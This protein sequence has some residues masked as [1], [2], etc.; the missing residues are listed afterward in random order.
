ME[1][2]TA[3]LLTLLLLALLYWYGIS[4]F[5]SLE[6]LGI[7]VIKPYPYIGSFLRPWKVLCVADDIRHARTYGRVWG[8]YEGSWP[9]VFIADIEM[10]K[11]IMIKDF[12]HFTD[13]PTLFDFEY[14]RNQMDM[15]PAEQWKVLR[16]L[17]GP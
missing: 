12:D 17:V 9:Q 2:L 7:P 13:R 4:S 5:G 10:A 3:F 11:R 6:R 1:P 14:G 8:Q 16:S 15:L